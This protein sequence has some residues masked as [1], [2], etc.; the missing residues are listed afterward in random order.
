M[1]GARTCTERTGRAAVV[2]S[3]SARAQCPIGHYKC[4]LCLL[5]FRRGVLACLRPE[6]A[7]RKKNGRFLATA[8]SAPTQVAKILQ[9][10]LLLDRSD[11]VDLKCAPRHHGTCPN[12]PIP[13]QS[14]RR[15]EPCPRVLCAPRRSRTAAGTRTGAVTTGCALIASSTTPDP[16]SVRVS[17]KTMRTLVDPRQ[18]PRSRQRRLCR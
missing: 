16:S 11:L 1:G 6:E 2:A 14:T 17:K 9:V 3:A 4:R 10:K 13:C 12:A 8:P 18:Q 15:S 5:G 7:R